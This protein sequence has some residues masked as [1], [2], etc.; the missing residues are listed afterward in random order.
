[1]IRLLKQIFIWPDAPV[2]ALRSETHVQIVCGNCG[3]D[4]LVPRKT[5]L[6]EDGRC[7]HC[8]GRSYIPAARLEPIIA[9]RI[10]RAGRIRLVG[11]RYA[12][13]GRGCAET[14]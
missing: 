9:E 11:G 8:G 10:K 7:S 2:A 5:L 6:C 1:M 3:G 12:K 4:D 13:R 14:R